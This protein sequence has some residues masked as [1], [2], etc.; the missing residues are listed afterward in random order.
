M[1]LIK[2]KNRGI[3]IYC[4]IVLFSFLSPFIFFVFSCSLVLSFPFCYSKDVDMRQ[5]M[6]TAAHVRH[7]QFIKQFTFHRLVY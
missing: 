4:L 1:F 6:T 7:L 3:F 2:N 5:E